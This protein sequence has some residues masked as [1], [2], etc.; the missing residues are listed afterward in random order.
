MKGI[1]LINS[2]LRLTCCS[3]FKS[4]TLRIALWHDIPLSTTQTIV[5]C[6]L[7]QF[8][9]VIWSFVLLTLSV[10]CTFIISLI[11]SFWYTFMKNVTVT[12]STMDAWC[13]ANHIYFFCNMMIGSM[14]IGFLFREQRSVNL[15]MSSLAPPLMDFLGLQL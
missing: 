4:R 5:P 1:F 15:E 7:I 3:R 6:T 14:S 10:Y 8:N 2:F 13:V 12:L 9:S 11:R